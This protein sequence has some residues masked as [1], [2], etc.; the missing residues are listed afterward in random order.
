LFDGE[1]KRGFFDVF[2][3][4]DV[5]V[6]AFCE[7]FGGVLVAVEAEDEGTELLGLIKRLVKVIRVVVLN[8][9]LT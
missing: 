1:I 5:E 2:G 4:F 3:V 8:N 6:V 9:R 7:F